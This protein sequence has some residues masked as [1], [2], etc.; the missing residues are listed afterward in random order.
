MFNCRLS[1]V[2]A[3]RAFFKDA[4]PR[5]HPKTTND[6]LRLNNEQFLHIFFRQVVL[7]PA[8]VGRAEGPEGFTRPEESE[9][10]NFEIG[11]IGE[12]KTTR[13]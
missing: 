11:R 10:R 7:L 4:A 9:K 1:S 12:L 2:V 8:G 5:A 6:H 13:S 3:L